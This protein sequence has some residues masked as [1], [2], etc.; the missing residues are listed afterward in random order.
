MKYKAIITVLFS[1][2]S[3]ID[4]SN[5]YQ[6]ESL[7]IT[8]LHVK[9]SQQDCVVVECV[10]MWQEMLGQFID[11]GNLEIRG[12]S[13]YSTQFEVTV[14]FITDHYGNIEAEYSYKLLGHEQV[15]KWNDHDEEWDY[16]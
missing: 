10:E 1:D 5:P 11:E 7:L 14:S 16:F 9:L 2:I 15:G 8:P 6:E 4:T 12:D 3:D 13:L